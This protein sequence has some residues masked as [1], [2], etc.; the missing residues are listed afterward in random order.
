MK[1]PVILLLFLLF[2][3]VTYAGET[4]VYSNE[5]LADTVGANTPDSTTFRSK[6]DRFNKTMEKIIVYSPLP[7]VSYSTETNWLIGL[8]KINA[9][10]LG[11][12]DQH[13][14][15][16]QPSHITALAYFT[17]NKQYKV[18]VTSD[19]MFGKNR[20]QSFTE[21]LFIDFP[22]FYFGVGDD[23]HIEDECLVET[24]N[25]S[26][27]QIFGYKITRKW[28]IGLKYHYNNYFKVDTVSG[29]VCNKELP[30][31][32]V[33][34][35][36]QS[37]I[38]INISREARDNRFNARKG[39]FLFI[40]YLNYGKWI[41]SKFAY[42]SVIMDY[43]KYI[44][45]L[46]WLTVAGQIYGEFKFGDIPVQSLSLMGGDNRM[47]GIYIGRF[48]D[49]TMIEGQV[50]ARFPIYW[51]FGGVIFTGL[52]EVAP[53]LKAYTLNGIKWTYG[54]GIRMSVN[55]ATRTNIRFDV[56]FF[57]HKPLFFFTFAEA[58]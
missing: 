10:R 34:E 15:T 53:T 41:G 14:T 47:R 57:Q 21:L 32:T 46:R 50:E 26:L 29:N 55:Q 33:N 38:G 18:A 4:T 22:N 35:G 31:L 19:L 51:I 7:V 28:Y 36:T 30:D 27:T 39:S 56:G 52:G 54:A 12:K 11:T 48:R 49:K 9:F 16:F 13:D 8:T 37:G 17:L 42:H 25:F 40:E 1:H 5:M 20:Y 58:F 3:V 45:P 2:G 24:E 44:T 23:T 43:R 6:L